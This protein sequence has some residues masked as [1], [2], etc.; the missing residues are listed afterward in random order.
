MLLLY[1]WRR[2]KRHT[3]ERIY[4]PLC[5][6]FILVLRRTESDERAD[7]HSTM[8]LLYPSLNTLSPDTIKHLH[9]TML[10]LYRNPCNILLSLYWKFT[11]HYASTLSARQNDI[12]LTEV[13]YIPLCFYFILPRR[14]WKRWRKKIYIPLCFYFIRARRASIIQ[15][16][17]IYI[18]LCFYFIR[19]DLGAY[20]PEG[21]FT[22]HYASTLWRTWIMRDITDTIYIPLCFY[23]IWS[24]ASDSERLN[25]F[26]FHYASTL[27]I[28][29]ILCKE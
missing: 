27:S 10:L 19:L 14:K 13:I 6:Y 21:L 28:C 9:S 17:M 5:F 12:T 24:S 3:R 1:R 20:V 2:W 26:T 16:W 29:R 8:L 22:F 11:F 18:P 4:I 23:F 7:L 15:S 25:R